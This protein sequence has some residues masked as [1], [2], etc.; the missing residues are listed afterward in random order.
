MVLTSLQEEHAEPQWTWSLGVCHGNLP[1]GQNKDLEKLRVSTS[2]F[3]GFCSNLEVLCFDTH[4][5][6]LLSSHWVE[7]GQKEL[8]ED[9]GFFFTPCEDGFRGRRKEMHFFLP[10]FDKQWKESDH[11]EAFLEAKSAFAWISA[12]S[13]LMTVSKANTF[14]CPFPPQSDS[15]SPAFDTQGRKRRPGRSGTDTWIHT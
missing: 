8:T 3:K 2:Y 4:P 9:T 10:S 1:P 15:H 12:L 5:V 13:Y 11:Q 14:P 7:C 6:I